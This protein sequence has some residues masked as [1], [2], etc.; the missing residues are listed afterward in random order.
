MVPP[1]SCTDPSGKVPWP[2]R[3]L[4]AFLE[5]AKVWVRASASVYISD[6]VDVPHMLMDYNLTH[7]AR[8]EWPRNSFACN[9]D[10]GAPR[11]YNAYKIRGSQDHDRTAYYFVAQMHLFVKPATA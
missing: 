3:W 6:I 7:F 2:F 9:N 8:R 11:S 1:I 4:G 10:Q 5:A